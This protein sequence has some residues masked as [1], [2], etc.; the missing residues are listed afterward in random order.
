MY[1]ISFANG[2]TDNDTYSSLEEAA[3]A[4]ASINGW[5]SAH[6]GESYEATETT[7]AYPVYE[8]AEEASDEDADWAYAPT[9]ERA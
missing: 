1:R 5:E 2:T 7:Y 6:M 4:I 8:T 9:I 3:Q